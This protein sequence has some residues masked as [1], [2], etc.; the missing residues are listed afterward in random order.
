MPR[1]AHRRLLSVLAAVVV[2]VV[3]LAVAASNPARADAVKGSLAIISVSDAGTGLTGLTGAAVQGRSTSVVVEA[4]D[5]TGA[6]MAVTRATTVRLT[7]SGPGTLGGTTTGTIAKNASR[8]TITGATYSTFANGVVLTASVTGGVSLDQGSATI[9]V[10]STAVK[11]TAREGTPLNVTDPGCAAPTAANPVCGFLRLP[12]GGTGTVLM[13]VESC[14]GVF[15]LGEVACFTG[16]SQQPAGLVTAVASLKDADGNKLYSKTDPATFVVACD[17]TLCSNG[18]VPKF[19]VVADLTNSG[20]LMPVFDCPAKGLLGD[21]QQACL[22]TV[23]SKRDNA[24]DL[25]SVIL[26]DHDIRASHP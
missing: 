9:N 2:A 17:K 3:P 19:P 16:S 6:P 1:P 14:V 24:G 13:Y 18:G 25:Y 22:D 7:A 20:D 26:F 5:E 21:D 10:A 11:A 12:N 15:K 23:Q 4:R 8:V